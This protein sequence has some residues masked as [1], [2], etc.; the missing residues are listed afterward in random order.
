MDANGQ[1][2]WMLSEESQWTPLGNPSGVEYDPARRRLRLASQRRLP[3][4][5]NRW[6]LE[7]LLPSTSTSP[8]FYFT[9][10]AATPAP[11][12][13]TALAPALLRRTS[14]SQT[15]TLT[16]RGFQSGAL[17]T[18]GFPDGRYTSR[19]GLTLAAPSAPDENGLDETA[20][21]VDLPLHQAGPWSLR[22]TNPDG[23]Q[24]PTFHFTVLPALAAAV[25]ITGL[26][27]ASPSFSA[28]AQTLTVSGQ[29]FQA[30][31]RAVL[32]LPG[33][34]V[35]IPAEQ[36]QAV[37][38][39]SFSVAL[40]AAAL[41]LEVAQR[42]LNQVPQTRD[43][44][45]TRAYWQPD[46]RRVVATGALP[47]EVGIYLPPTGQ[48]PTDL[49]MGYD[50]ILYLALSGASDE[51]GADGGQLV[52]VDRRDR[53]SPHTIALPEG[54]RPWRLAAAPEGGVW[55]LD[56]PT[57][58]GQPRQLGRVMGYPLPDRAQRLYSADTFRP[59][60]ENRQPPRLSVVWAGTLDAGED[61]VALACSAEG[62][63]ALLSWVSGAPAQVRVAFGHP[64][65]TLRPDYRW[66]PPLVLQGADYPYS[67]TWLSAD[68]LALLL[69]GLT[70]EAPVY[71]W[72]NIEGDRAA[73]SPAVPTTGPITV[74][75]T[76]QIY[77]LNAYD[78]GPFLH[79]VT[80]PPH[81]PTREGSYPLQAL[82]LQA[83]SEQGL[84]Q[85]RLPI[86]SGSTQTVWHRLY[87]EAV[88]PANS[89]LR[90]FLAASDEAT[91]PPLWPQ[92]W[93]EHRL[94][95]R[96]APGVTPYADPSTQEDPES[97]QA[98]QIPCGAW[99]SSPSELPYHPGLLPCAPEPNRSGLFTVLVQRAGRQVRSLQGR[100]LWV[101]LELLGDGRSTPELAALRAYGS[102]FSY[103]NRYLPG[104]YHETQFGPDADA[105]GPS[106]AADF[107]ERFLDNFEG[108][109]T[110]L[111]DRI[112]NAYLLTDPRTVPEPGLDWL[113]SWIG[114]SLDVTYPPDRRRALLEATPAL[115]RQR[116][117]LNGLSQALNVATNGAVDSGE[118]V[119]LEDFRLRRTF[120]TILG[121]DLADETDPLLGDIAVSGNSF[122]GD[123]LVLGDE[124][125]REFL[126]L[127]RP[128]LPAE[129]AT[130]ADQA[131]D[132]K[133]IAAFFD[134]LAYRV[135]VFCHQQVAPQDL[136][137]VRR[138][139]AL[140]TPAHVL[141][142]VVTASRPFMVSLAALVGVDTYLSAKP[143][144]GAVTVDQS[145]L[146]LNDVIQ[147]P[148][149]LDP[150]LMGSFDPRQD[151]ARYP[152][153]QG[154]APAAVPPDRPFLLDASLSQAFAGR[155]I[156]RYR[157]TLLGPLPP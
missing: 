91:Q 95:D 62:R 80:L 143:P 50:G 137:L 105:P 129:G 25:E 5:A 12:Q 97:P 4:W 15:L 7:L 72:L 133:A 116:G 149:S 41:A 49:A 142:K 57:A 79:G 131:A 74:A 35:A 147:R 63:L 155:R 38:A 96:F 89:G 52:M 77:P 64:A 47:G 42:W 65:G 76:G 3:I 125:Q 88:L 43:R 126:A 75:P 68:R 51:T 134:S 104:L 145:I 139:T 37:T 39:T 30:G 10:A 9:V 81:Y 54:F 28:A 135:T 44:F 36:L 31:M 115:Y 27:P 123:T 157:W 2:F 109:L 118:I 23:S 106:T 87:L 128:L 46:Q 150:R 117:T 17:L 107:L 66:S 19:S 67:L 110:P 34:A 29:G 18:V 132:D 69:P 26:S 1:R 94:G 56:R 13:I 141:A 85:G 22:L 24:S 60:D 45:N 136:G 101:R 114:L 82:S 111:E 8:R 138:I 11:L 53:W 103:L 32:H 113:G 119:V 33:G 92:D 6:G 90:I 124:T 122:V 86:D 48:V 59:C 40:D 146:G 148:A 152:L 61:P 99:V 151:D 58:L 73:N 144:V 120:A 71:P 98:R 14:D 16:G 84:A 93:F 154:R 83:Y 112:A 55:V 130:S 102:R 153:A 108:L 100:Y 140:E 70:T 127:F 121:A 156:D 21:T 78:G 20:L